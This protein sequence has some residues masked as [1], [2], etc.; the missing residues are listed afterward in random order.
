MG[1]I[2]FALP[3]QLYS[4]QQKTIYNE[5]RIQTY[6]CSKNSFQNPSKGNF[7]YTAVQFNLHCS[8]SKIAL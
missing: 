8:V 6:R 1:S 4:L 5:Y 3:I 2:P 7:A